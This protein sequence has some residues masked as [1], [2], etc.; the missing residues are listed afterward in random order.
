MSTKLPIF[1]EIPAHMLT[2]E[3]GQ[4]WLTAESTAAGWRGAM[5][6]DTVEGFIRFYSSLHFEH[7][8]S[9]FALEPVARWRRDETQRRPFDLFHIADVEA[10]VQAAYAGYVTVLRQRVA[11]AEADAAAA[12]EAAADAVRARMHTI[13]RV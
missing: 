2:R 6:P 7:L 4:R 8:V 11:R 3:D 1:T 9:T 10:A 12:K 5:P 13:R